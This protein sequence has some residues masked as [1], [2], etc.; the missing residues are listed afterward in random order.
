M[1][2]DTDRLAWWRELRERGPTESTL[3]HVL[4]TL[5]T[6]ADPEGGS[7]Y[8]SQAKIAGGAALAEKTVQRLLRRAQDLGWVRAWLVNVPGSRKH[9]KHYRLTV[10]DG[11]EAKRPRYAAGLIPRARGGRFRGST[12]LGSAINPAGE[13]RSAPLHSGGT[14]PGENH[15]STKEEV[16]RESD[17]RGNAIELMRDGLDDPTIAGVL[18]RFEVSERVIRQWRLEEGFG[19]AR[20]HPSGSSGRGVR[21]E[22]T[23]ASETDRAAIRKLLDLQHSPAEVVRLLAA[24]NVTLDQ[25]N[26]EATRR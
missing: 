16:L 18:W 25:V 14:S 3:R 7:C 19:A 6:W 24:R 9:T 2:R 1:P 13:V 4:L 23:A 8:P 20:P 15:Y 17:I 21:V 10:P 12:P 26:A 22:S 11:T 5:S